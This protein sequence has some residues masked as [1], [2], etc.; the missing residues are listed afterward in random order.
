MLVVVLLLVLA[1]VGT[2]GSTSA[3][4]AGSFAYDPPNDVAWRM[5]DAVLVSGGKA[6]APHL[7]EAHTQVHLRLASEEAAP[8]GVVGDILGGLRQCFRSFSGETEV[9]MADGT[10]KPI[11]KI[12][13]GDE[14]W[15]LDPETGEAGARVVIAVWPHEDQLLDFMVEG[16]SVTTTEDHH[17]WNQTDRDCQET[18]DIDPGDHFDRRRAVGPGRR[19]RL[20]NSTLRNG[21]GPLGRRD[22]FLLRCRGKRRSASPQPRGVRAMPARHRRSSGATFTGSRRRTASAWVPT[23]RWT[24]MEHGGTTSS[25]SRMGLSTISTTTELATTCTW[26]S[27]PISMP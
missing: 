2:L 4:L 23:I 9:L 3:A 20:A 10:T 15:A 14:A 1:A 22:S 6:G 16:G 7:A 24:L 19:T 8:N 18:R 21:I 12:V 13:L 5:P 17:F 11:A 26:N 25:S 27:S